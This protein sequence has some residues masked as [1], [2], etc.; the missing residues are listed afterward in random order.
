MS[1]FF[2]PSSFAAG[3]LIGALL[4]YAWALGGAPLS[5]LTSSNPGLPA[6]GLQNPSSSTSG[7]VSVASQ[8]AGD[9]VLVTSVT[10]PPPGVWVAV[11]DVIGTG[12]S[13]DLGN[14]LG[15]ARVPGPESNVTV[16]LLRPTLP[17]ERYAIQLYR[18]NGDGV[19][20][21]SDDSVYVDL[22]TGERVVAYFIATP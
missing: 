17:A 4:G 2:S 11:R 20:D 21:L 16:P 19:F 22:D 15:A 7:A 18:D 3:I 10:V 8:K 12:S 9:S 5:V 14:V 1:R 13:S 6:S